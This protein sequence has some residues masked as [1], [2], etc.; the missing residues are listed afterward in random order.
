M[1]VYFILSLRITLHLSTKT[2]TKTQT[3]LV[4]KANIQRS[5]STKIKHSHYQ[6]LMKFQEGRVKNKGK[7]LFF[8]QRRTAAGS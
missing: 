4:L 8:G 2:H 5:N 3:S 7:L 1:C 6:V